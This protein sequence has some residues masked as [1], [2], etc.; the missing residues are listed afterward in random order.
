MQYDLATLEEHRTSKR[1]G[2]GRGSKGY[3]VRFTNEGITADELADGLFTDELMANFWT[4]KNRAGQYENT[5]VLPADSDSLGWVVVPKGNRIPK[6]PAQTASAALRSA[7]EDRGIILTISA[8]KGKAS[9]FKVAFNGY[10]E[11]AEQPAQATQAET[12][13]SEE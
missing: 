8:A 12:D 10:V 7:A 9:T 5:L 4:V 13:D 1:P 2:S 6:N 11:D 3:D